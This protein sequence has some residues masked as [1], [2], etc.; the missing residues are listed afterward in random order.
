MFFSI[1]H[2]VNSIWNIGHLSEFS[3]LLCKV[4]AIEKLF[5]TYNITSLAKE[6][7]DAHTKI[8]K[9]SSWLFHLVLCLFIS[10]RPDVYFNPL[11]TGK[12][13][14]IRLFITLYHYSHL[15]N[16]WQQ[17]ITTMAVK[18]KRNK[19]K[20]KRRKKLCVTSLSSSFTK[21]TTLNGIYI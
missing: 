4:K 8:D 16:K 19:A 17:Q 9:R 12:R 15:T 7:T 13:L 14:R 11:L 2:F 6:H 5:T 18:W 1:Q 3:Y 10:T 21:A 20:N